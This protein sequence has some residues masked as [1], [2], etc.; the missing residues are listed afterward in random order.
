MSTQTSMNKRYIEYSQRRQSL[1]RSRR[2][3]I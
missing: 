3:K 1:Q 2:L